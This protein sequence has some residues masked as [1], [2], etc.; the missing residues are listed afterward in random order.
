M[1]AAE[2]LYTPELLG[3]AVSLADVPPAPDLPF[4][5]S[6]RSKS[7]GSTLDLDLGLDGDGKV[8]ALGLKV[9]ACAVGQAA[10]AVFAA[11]AEGRSPEGLSQARKQVATWLEGTGDLPDWP[12]FAALKPARSYP[13][14]H[15]ALLLPWN[16]ALDALSTAQPGG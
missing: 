7:C 4:H 15:G 2:K 11:G 10:A 16:A 12:G 9:R 1:A 13:G 6:A 14:R 5:G 8:E 3:L